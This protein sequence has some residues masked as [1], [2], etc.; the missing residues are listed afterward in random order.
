[1]KEPGKELKIM[2]V[3]AEVMNLAPDEKTT[4]RSNVYTGMISKGIVKRSQEIEHLV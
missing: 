2:D 4:K 3:Q 1:M